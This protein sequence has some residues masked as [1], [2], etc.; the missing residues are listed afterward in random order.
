MEI[1]G[2]WQTGLCTPDVE[3]SAT[4]WNRKPFEMQIFQESQ[5]RVPYF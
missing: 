5:Q 1:I 2:R 3:L 4:A